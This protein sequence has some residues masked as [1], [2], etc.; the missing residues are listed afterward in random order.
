MNHEQNERSNKTTL[1]DVTTIIPR[2]PF[3]QDLSAED[4]ESF[5]TIKG[6]EAEVGRFKEI[7]RDYQ[8]T[9]EQ[10]SIISEHKGFISEARGDLSEGLFFSSLE[11]LWDDSLLKAFDGVDVDVNVFNRS[12]HVA[13]LESKAIKY[14]TTATVAETSRVVMGSRAKSTS[15]SVSST[16]GSQQILRNLFGAK[17]LA[18]EQ[19]HL[20]P[21]AAACSSHWYHMVPWVLQV[22]DENSQNWDYMQ[23]CIHGF[24]S[25]S[26]ENRD[27]NVG[28]KN[29]LTNR[30]NLANQK[31]Y[32]DKHHC[33]LI[34]PIL[35]ETGVKEWNCDGYSAIVLATKYTSNDIDYSADMVY[36]QI[37]ADS[38]TLLFATKA[39][40][41]TAR[42]VFE[43]YILCACKSF[44]DKFPLYFLHENNNVKP[45]TSRDGAEIKR[46]IF[47][48]KTKE[49]LEVFKKL[50]NA[51]VPTSKDWSAG[52]M[53]VRKIVFSK[54]ESNETP[55]P[56][57]AL[58]LG[59]A[60]SNWLYLH[61][62]PL[63]PACSDD[64]SSDGSDD[65]DTSNSE[66]TDHGWLTDTFKRPRMDEISFYASNTFDESLSD[67]DTS[68]RLR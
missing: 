31:L 49:L 64:S 39:E 60:V 42:A 43:Q 21:Q 19:A 17:G 29:F 18:S 53:N 16:D 61:E 37:N 9:P 28:I 66:V 32:L 23:K 67:D 30:I 6:M 5:Q 51:P 52:K 62:V 54:A 41:D 48:E 56:D 4:V 33:V 26:N 35:N 8:L 22:S 3:T 20:M 68:T 36:K 55:A 58:L 11:D 12:H 44:K 25:S 57:P 63:L 15:S 2:T 7:L 40:C 27:A 59:K 24:S 38:G 47:V 34:I 50:I 65:A 1:D 14:E 45:T 13:S 46:D 10:R